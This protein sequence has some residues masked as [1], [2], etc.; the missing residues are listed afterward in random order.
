MNFGYS[1]SFTQPGLFPWL[2]ENVVFVLLCKTCIFHL[3]ISVF[4]YLCIFVFGCSPSLTLAGLFPWLEEN[5]VRITEIT[6]ASEPLPAC[7]YNYQRRGS[8]LIHHTDS[9]A[10]RLS[11]CKRTTYKITK[12]Y[13]CA[14]FFFYNSEIVTHKFRQNL[15]L[16]LNSV[17]PKLIIWMPTYNPDI[18]SENESNGSNILKLSITL[19]TSLYGGSMLMLMLINVNVKTTS[20]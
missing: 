10:T 5:F 3:C 20:L 16:I 12:K 9:W 19:T 18:W 11:I 1:P 17:I 2:E 7:Q 4:L 13:Y 15:Y 6:R 8:L 14:D